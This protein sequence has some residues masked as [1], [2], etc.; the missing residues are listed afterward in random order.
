VVS[1]GQILGSAAENDSTLQIF[2]WGV[3]YGLIGAVFEP[4]TSEV[5]QEIWASAVSDGL[6]NVLPPDLLAVMTVRG[7]IDEPTA[8]GQA[9]RSGVNA[10][11]F[12]KM[13]NNARNPI[14]PEEAAVALRRKIIPQSGAPGVPSFDTAIQEGNLGNQWGPVIQQLATAI[15][16]PSDVLR[17]VL[18]GQVPDGTDPRALYQQVGGE[19]VDPNTNFDWYTFLFNTEGEGPSPIQALEMARRGIIPYNGTGPGVTS[20]EQA[21]LEGPWRDKWLAAFQGL[22]NYV[23][24]PRTVT[25]L[26]KQGA[27]TVAQAQQYFQ[28]S[29]LS[30]ELATIYTNAATATKT[31]AVKHLSESN[32]MT[33]LNDKLIT[34]AEAVTFLEELGYPADEANILATTG[35][36]AAS[37]TDLKR[38]VNRVGTYYIA[39]KIDRAN[40]LTMLGTLGLDP[41]AGAAQVDGWDIDRAANVRV[42]TPAQIENAWEFQLLTQA[43]AQA[44]LEILGYTPLDAW[45]VLSIKA[46]QALPNKPAGGPGLVQ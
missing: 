9:A 3:L 44:E 26:L 39:H 19:L 41:A 13:V 2:T 21:F 27:I 16:T 43:E 5:T 18:A 4:V 15:P 36:A 46:K 40:A 11:D 20:F 45:T 6:N 30:P 14:A 7:W 25:A 32:I 8:A 35:Q 33:L 42:L 31:A 29:G 23:P 17:G 37:I 38:N 1:I 12:G 22:G 34:T 28:F 24:P 10:G